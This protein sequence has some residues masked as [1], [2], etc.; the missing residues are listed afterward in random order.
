MMADGIFRYSAPE[1][2]P[3]FLLWQVSNQ[4]QRD[5]RA[6][7]KPFALT[8]SQFVLLAN[9]E[10]LQEKISIVSQNDLAHH[11]GIDVMMTSELVRKLEERGLILRTDH[12]RDSR[13]RSIRLTAEGKR[14]VAQVVPIVE[15]VDRAFFE[16]LGA[17]VEAF[18]A[19]LRMFGSAAAK[20]DHD[21]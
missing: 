7:L 9:L 8:H 4:W 18:V 3:G 17:N 15:A 10:W 12:P 1:D 2:S 6:A 5:Q 16:R 20:Q 13:A 19:L 21:E 11:A 14:F